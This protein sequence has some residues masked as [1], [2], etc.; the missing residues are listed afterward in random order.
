MRKYRK[1][2]IGLIILACAALIV[3]TMPSI[4]N[5][6]ER[7]KITLRVATGHPLSK[8]T[9]WVEGIE[10]FFIPEV[11]KRVLERTDKYQVEIKG[12]YGGSLAKLGEVLE[13]VE[14]GL[15]DIGYVLPL[16]EMAKIDPYNFTFWVPFGTSD[17]DKLATAVV[18]TVNHFPIFDQ[19]LAKYNQ[20]RLGN[21]YCITDSYQIISN[22]PL[23]KMEDFK[24]VK[25]AHAG[26]FLPLIAA[27]GA[28]PVQAVFTEIYTSMDT[29]VFNGFVMSPDSAVAFRIQEVGK[30]LT[31]LDLGAMEAGVLTVNLNTFNKLPKEVQDIV[32]EVGSEWTWDVVNRGKTLEANAWDTFKKAGVEVY[33]LPEKERVRWANKINDAGVLS[34][35]MQACNAKGMPCSDIAEY[36]VQAVEK[37]GYKF[38]YKPTLR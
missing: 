31:K 9:Y 21:P 29:G 36:Y 1:S 22:V 3:T 30:Y 35:A 8:G 7:Q 2:G 17:L 37:T 27:L 16:A 19:V 12:F 34:K 24:G 10:Y 25:L 11:Q 32:L 26:S 20:R 4:G 5:T 13:T 23:R 14:N 38:P 33:T 28:T 6:A 18:D 15:A